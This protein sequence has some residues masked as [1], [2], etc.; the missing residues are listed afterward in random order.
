MENSFNILDLYKKYYTRK[1]A[2]EGVDINDYLLLSRDLNDKD[3]RKLFL[4][5]PIDDF[6][7]NLPLVLANNKFLYEI[8]PPDIPVKPYFDCEIEA[9]GMTF[10]DSAE[11]I[12]LFIGFLKAEFLEVFDIKLY[13]FDFA[14]L[15][16]CREN[17]LSYHI[18]IQNKSYF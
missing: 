16:S 14:L 1:A 18:V 3:A 4:R 17:K 15:N 13:S 2:L 10:D 6:E 9:D 12:E 7:S 11:L 5:I 8:L